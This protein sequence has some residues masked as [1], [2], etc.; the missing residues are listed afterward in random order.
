M[1]VW[2]EV[3]I[4]Y[5]QIV[6]HIKNVAS[7]WFFLCFL[8]VIRGEI[9]TFAVMFVTCWLSMVISVFATCVQHPVLT[10]W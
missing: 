1:D 2:H 4:L 10:H 5:W 8:L 7:L 6:T 3:A 9:C